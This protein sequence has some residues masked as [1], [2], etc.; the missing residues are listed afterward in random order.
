MLHDLIKNLNAR[1]YGS[2]YDIRTKRIVKYK[3]DY[4][5]YAG[6]VYFGN[7]FL[8]LIYSAFNYGR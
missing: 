7:R 3:T 6:E 1:R 5:I 2:Y 8:V 4:I